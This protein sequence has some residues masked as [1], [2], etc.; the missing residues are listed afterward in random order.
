MPRRFVVAC[1]A[2]VAA[3]VWP[4]LAL[5]FDVTVTGV[6]PSV[7]GEP[8][9]FTAVVAGATGELS[10]EWQFGE[11]DFQPGDAA[12]THSFGAPGLVSVQVIATD[13]TGETASAFF[14]HLVHYPLTDRRPTSASP[15]IY[16]AA[17]KRVYSVN[18]DNDTVTVIDAASATKLSEVAVYKKPES[19]AL[20]PAGKLWVVHQDDYAVA[21]LNPDS[22]TVESGF[23]LP[24]ASQPV[25]VAMSPAGDAAY[26]S[27]FALGKLL[28]LD[29]ATGAVLGEVLVGEKPRGIAVSHDGKVAYVTRFLS[30]DTGGEVVKVDTSTLTV[31][32]RVLLAADS[33]TV[34][35]DQKSRGVPNYLFSVALSPDGRQGWIPGK[36]D[37]I[38]RGKLR[39]GQDITHDTV[40]RPL[41]AVID[42]QTDQELFANRVDLDDRSMPM[43]VEFSPYGNF[44]ILALGGSN[45]IEVR[46]VN[47]PTQV[48]SAI[49]DVGAFPRASV[50]A[51]DGKLFVQASLSREVLVYDMSANLESFDQSTPSLVA[52]IPAVASEKLP[53]QILEGKRIF[54]DAEDTRMDFEGYLTCGGCHFEGTDDGRVYDFS[55][56]G[57]GLRNTIT[58]LGRRGTGQGRLNWSAALDEVQDFEHQIRELFGG[59]GF[60]ADE[61]F[62][63]GTHD[64]PLGDLKAGLSPELDALAAY[65]ASL[66][67]VNPSPFRNADGTLTADGAA[68]QL[69]FEKLGC[70]FC[71]AGP[72]F[73]DS[74]RG[75]L[76][77]VGTITASSGMRAGQPLLG[78]DT[79]TLLG[80][81]ETPPYLHDGSAVTLRDVLTT[82]NPTGL[83]GF[84][85]SLSLPE[86][87][88]LVAYL[89]QIDDAEPV[90]RLPFEPPAAAAGAGAQGG[91]AGAGAGAALGGA[92]GQ[93]APGSGGA[94][95]S[96]GT[97]AGNTAGASAVPA[98]TSDKTTPRASEGCGCRIASSGKTPVGAL[99]TW[100]F[101]VAALWRRVRRGKRRWYGALASVV[102][103]GTTSC[104]SDG[105]TPKGKPAPAGTAG[106]QAMGGAANLPA[107]THPDPWLDALGSREVTDA[108]VCARNRADAFSAVLCGVGGRP[109]LPDLA[110]L[111]ALVGLGE[112][113]AFALTG[114]STS[115]VTKSVS[116]LNPRLLVFPRVGDDLTA[117]ATLVAL[118][119][120]RGEQFVEIV[121]RDTV[122]RDLNF[123]L[124]SFEQR[125]SYDAAG[126]SLAD[127]L[128]EAVEHDWTTYSV[129]DQDDLETTPFDCKSCHQPGGHGTKLM[130]RMQELSSPWLHWFPQRFV[131][132]TDSDRLL[133]AEFMAVHQDDRQYGGLPIAVIANAL[134]EGS[135]AQ[136]EALVRAEGFADQ[137]NPFDAQIAREAQSGAS[138]TWQA[139]FDA[140][141]RGEAIAV[142]YPGIDVTDAAKRDAAT[143][144]YR[145]VVQGLAPRESLLDV[146]DVF[147]DDAQLKLSFLPQPN[148]DGKAVLLQMCARCHDG[149]GNPE[150]PKNQFNV[151]KLE[152]VSRAQKETAMARVQASD[153][154]RMPPWRAGSLTPAALEAVLAELAQ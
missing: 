111:L 4:R 140:H 104:A 24:Y 115:L 16:D 110:S 40:V 85:S 132:Q 15:I 36:K 123:Y 84:V 102:A 125:C 17:R 11:E 116:A 151:R 19:I 97:G 37:N 20:T 71:H 137:P 41:A 113:R 139:R 119:F 148:A 13:G 114:N 130:L 9:T 65:V 154:T 108:R 39:D 144:S 67:R 45:R 26:V 8:H 105:G 64:Q 106:A 28:K 27:L 63:A 82:K 2:L 153:E 135:G 128:T 55:T 47:Q 134:D 25:G 21:V 73:T 80:I 76:H 68:G 29:P 1:S 59:T 91:V 92:A 94:A 98:A 129:Y 49:G 23:R 146:R 22:M 48:F 60:I 5:A 122:S 44:A 81:W 70:N 141:L 74:A 127:L 142:P 77:D 3:L 87:D 95:G 32:T 61:Q 138:P 118:G 75:L 117:P 112:E 12:A 133:G 62:H 126:C 88:Q 57:E 150:L 93:S 79:P 46:D 131:Q 51:P 121:S 35:G 96:G 54:H 69:L 100:L 120:V 33:E 38:F 143:R 145:D 101:G 107:V 136:L 30:P 53:A 52:T 99:G 66:E 58:L 147:A 89:R 72:A 56:R 18:Q 6:E 7:V 43:H 109:A 14:R 149:R 78:L 31:A 90:R 42:T 124:V 86:L 103:L 10:Y 50:L 34:D 152:T 83:H